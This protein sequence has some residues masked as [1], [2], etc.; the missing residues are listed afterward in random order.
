MC[1]K[2]HAWK[3]SQHYLPLVE[4]RKKKLRL[5]FDLGLAKNG[6][7]LC[8]CPLQ[9]QNYHHRM[10][11]LRLCFCMGHSERFCRPKRI[12][13]I[14]S[15]NERERDVLQGSEVVLMYVTY[16][17]MKPAPYEL[18]N[19]GF[20]WSW[21]NK[22]RTS[23]HPVSGIRHKGE[24][25]SGWNEVRTIESLHHWLHAHAYAWR[26]RQLPWCWVTMIMIMIW[27]THFCSIP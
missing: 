1:L 19:A 23:N 16:E 8:L 10:V 26:W 6:F 18:F 9:D 5:T 4:T 12:T 11:L 3:S 22:C 21:L 13:F 7:S 27:C 20:F 14:E 15:A 25:I 2:C 24:H 17:A